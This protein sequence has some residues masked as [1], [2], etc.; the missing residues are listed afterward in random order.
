MQVINE[1]DWQSL[2]ELAQQEVYDFFLFIKQRYGQTDNN[3][4]IALI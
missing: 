3:E 2:P 1:Q 4:T